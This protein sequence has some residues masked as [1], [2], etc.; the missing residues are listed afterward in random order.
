MVLSDFH[1]NGAVSSPTKCALLTGRYQQRAG[2]DGVLLTNVSKL[3]L[4]GLQPEETTFTDVLSANEYDVA[5][6]GKWHLGYLPKYSPLNHGFATF[7][8]FLA[9][10]VDYKA[11]LDSQ[12]R[13]DWYEGNEQKTP[14]GYLTEI[15]NDKSV[16]FIKKQHSKPF[17]L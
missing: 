8:G 3:R 1:S 7:E 10:N 4:T 2:L 14:H 13:P 5:M 9:G 16:E 17:C 11:F 6:F 12:G 15:I